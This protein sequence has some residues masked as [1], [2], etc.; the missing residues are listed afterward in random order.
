MK[1]VTVSVTKIPPKG[2]F[3]LRWLCSLLG[4][5]IVVCRRKGRKEGAG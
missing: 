4:A 2:L 5:T 3:L 1:T